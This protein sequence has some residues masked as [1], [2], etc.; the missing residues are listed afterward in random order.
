[1]VTI[2]SPSVEAVDDILECWVELAESQ[3]RHGSHLLAEPNRPTAR[4][5]ITQYVVMGGMLVATEY[6]QKGHEERI[7][8]FGRSIL[9]FVMFDV[10]TGAY[11]LDVTKGVIHNLYVKRNRRSEGIGTELL[12]AGENALVEAGADVI[13]LQAMADN[14][15]AIRFYRRHGYDSH[16]VTFE[17]RTETTNQA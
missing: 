7:E 15:A 9:G 3:R 2:E 6:S 13:S 10:E 1:M 8:R 16:R 4:N 5:T 14:E 11:E 12:A 17:K